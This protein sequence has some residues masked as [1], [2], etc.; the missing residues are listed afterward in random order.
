MSP[1]C[2][3]RWIR[4]WSNI[5]RGI[6]KESDIFELN[7]L[8]MLWQMTSNRILYIITAKNYK[9]HLW[10]KSTNSLL[11]NLNTVI[12]LFI[13]KNPTRCINVSNFYY[14][15]FIWSS[16]CFG[17]HTAHHQKP[18]TVKLHWQP[19]I[20]HTW[21][22]NGRVVGGLC[23]AHCAWQSPPTTRRT[24]FHVWKTRGQQ[25]SFR[26]LM[27]DGV[28]PVTCWVSYKYGIINVWY[29]AA[30]YWIFLY[31]LNYDARIDEHQVQ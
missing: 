13:K 27:M 14:S 25:C 8:W 17:R 16:T 18:K 15:I 22:V 31:E 21:K 26:L 5:V 11:R 19:L 7:F 4:F 30:S 12:M 9:P 28:S 3:S 6:K 10:G 20:F 24:S 1:R 29:I 23:Q 2:E